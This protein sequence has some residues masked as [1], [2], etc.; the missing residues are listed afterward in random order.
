MSDVEKLRNFIK[1][2]ELDRVCKESELEN[3]RKQS[4][5][6]NE[7]MKETFGRLSERIKNLEEVIKPKYHLKI[8]DDELNKCLIISIQNCSEFLRAPMALLYVGFYPDNLSISYAIPNKSS[9]ICLSEDDVVTKVSEI[10]SQIVNG[11]ISAEYALPL[12]YKKTG[13]I[14]GYFVYVAVWL[15]CCFFG[16]IGVFFGWLP[17]WILYKLSPYVWPLYVFAVLNI[18]EGL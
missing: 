11:D 18:A 3:S 6:D 10:I 7:N 4:V 2:K 15:L 16:W 1:E 8:E 12:W 13:K 14:I 9:D 5:I 17:S